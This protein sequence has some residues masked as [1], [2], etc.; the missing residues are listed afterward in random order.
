MRIKIIFSIF[1]KFCYDIHFFINF[2]SLTNVRHI[3]YI[4]TKLFL[5]S[6]SFCCV[7]HIYLSSRFFNASFMS[8]NF[9]NT[10]S[11][12]FS[13]LLLLL[14]SH[15]LQIIKRTSIS[16]KMYG[17]S[18]SSIFLYLIA[19]N[20]T[21]FPSLFLIYLFLLLFLYIINQAMCLFQS[22]IKL[23]KILKYYFIIFKKNFCRK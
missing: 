12:T 4:I 10:F 19:F 18:E 5:R 7:K 16:I 11:N 14:C 3:I 13:K 23:L 15:F 2:K 17:I 1:F 8:L 22:I 9:S 20:A 6:A 21:F